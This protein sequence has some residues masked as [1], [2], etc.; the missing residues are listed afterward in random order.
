MKESQVISPNLIIHY[1]NTFP[2]EIQKIKE[3]A[4]SHSELSARAQT[5]DDIGMKCCLFFKNRFLGAITINN[6][7]NVISD[8]SNKIIQ[9][10][11][12]DLFFQRGFVSN[13][14]N[15]RKIGAEI[16]FL[17]ILHEITEGK[18][19]YAST[20]PSANRMIGFFEKFNFKKVD[21]FKSFH[22]KNK[23]VELY[24]YKYLNNKEQLTNDRTEIIS[25]LQ[26]KL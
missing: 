26:Q 9:I 4:F 12:I 18:N 6:Y 23:I 24:L 1:Y 5:L 22:Q 7:S 13:E 3:E 19:I 16:L 20:R 15:N 14:L 10:Q 21:N 25:L 2:E 17:L 8:W 11:G